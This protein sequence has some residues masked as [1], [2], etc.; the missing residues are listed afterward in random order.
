MEN[1]AES[2]YGAHPQV[3]PAKPPDQSD[4]QLNGENP[5]HVYNEAMSEDEATTTA[6]MEE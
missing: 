2:T 5:S 1:N 4:G 3:P 6:T